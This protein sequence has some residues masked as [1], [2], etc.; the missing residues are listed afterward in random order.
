MEY[1]YLITETIREKIKKYNL[2]PR[3]LREI[4]STIDC[5]TAINAEPLYSTCVMLERR[6]R[7]GGER[8]VWFEDRRQKGLCLYILREIFM[9]DEYNRCFTTKEHVREWE[10]SHAYDELE[11]L[12]I[13]QVVND[14]LHPKK[15]LPILPQEWKVF[16]NA[17]R[18]FGD[19]Q[20]QDIVVYESKEWVEE[21][22][23]IKERTVREVVRDQLKQFVSSSDIWIR[24]NNVD[25][26][27]NGEFRE[28]M[29]GNK[30]ITIRLDA[31]NTK[32][33]A[34]YLLSISETPNYD[35][36]RKK[37][38]HKAEYVLLK[39]RM[40][41]CYPAMIL[42][43]DGPNEEDLEE[44]KSKKGGELKDNEKPLPLWLMVE[45]DKDGQANLILSAQEANLLKKAQYPFF[46]NGLAGSGKSTMLY[47][48]FA[49]VYAYQHKN[50]PEH[51]LLFLSYS[52][53]LV[54]KAR[55]YVASIL[56]LNHEFME[57]GNVHIYDDMEDFIKPFKIFLRQNFLTEEERDG[58][59]SNDKYVDYEKFQELY[60][61]SK[62]KEKNIISPDIVWSVIRIYIKG[63]N[64]QRFLAPDD[65]K[66]LI[67]NEGA[68]KDVTVD[69][70]IF[71]LAYDIW[72]KWYCKKYELDG[73]WDDLDLVR[74]IL[75]NKRVTKQYAA[76][77]C[78]EAQDFTRVET[79]LIIKLSKHSLYDLSSDSA[80]Q[81]IP[82]AFAG[83]PNQTISPTGFRVGS[84]KKLFTDAFMELVGKKISFEEYPLEI[85]YRS[86]EGIVNFSNV[87]QFIRHKLLE[88]VTSCTFQQAWDNEDSLKRNS[89]IDGFNYVAFYSLDSDSKQVLEGHIKKALSVITSEDGEYYVS[90]SDDA[91]D[92]EKS[93]AEETSRRLKKIGLDKDVVEQNNVYTAI[94]AKGLEFKSTILYRFASVEGSEKAI[95]AFQK[96][97]VSRE[98]LNDSEFYALTHF[99]TK[100]YVAVSRSKEVL[101]VLDTDE[102]YERFWK[103]LC[104][105]VLWDKYVRRDIVINRFN[106]QASF[107][108]LY[109]PEEDNDENYVKDYIKMLD[110]NFNPREEAERLFNEALTADDASSASTMRRARD[111][112]AQDNNEYMMQL[113]EAYTALYSGRMKQAGD[114]FVE[115]GEKD[116]A[117]STYWQSMSWRELSDLLDK[118]CMKK[119][120]ADFM[121][122]KQNIKHFIQKW[123]FHKEEF[124]HSAS[125]F[126]KSETIWR[127]IVDNIITQTLKI[128]KYDITDSLINSFED[129]S[130][131]FEYYGNKFLSTQATLH[132]KRAQVLNQGRE[133]DSEQIDRT[134][135]IRA[136]NQ[137]IATEQT[138]N[139]EFYWANLYNSENDSERI[140]WLRLLLKQDVILSKYSNV[141][142]A[143]QLSDES[144]GIVFTCLL[145][146]DF[147]KAV[148]Y[149]FPKD[150]NTK[151]N[152]LYA[153]NPI[154][155]FTEVVL[156]DFTPEKFYFLTDKVQ[157][158]ENNI[159][160]D[161]LP[162][163]IFDI[164]F[165]LRN[166]DES[167][168]P[169]W[170][171]F[172][173]M[174][175]DEHGNRILKQETNRI[176]ILESL[177]KLINKDGN[178]DKVLASC[179][180]EMLFDKDFNTARADKFKQTIINL[181]TQDLFFK[182]DFRR[183]TQRNKY[184]TQINDLDN[185]EHDTIKNNICR[186]AEHYLANVRKVNSSSMIGI[187]AMMRAYEICVAY[188]GIYPDYQNICTMYRKHLR[189][190]KEEEINTWM[191]QRIIFNQYLDNGILQRSSFNDFKQALEEKKINLIKVCDDFTKEDAARFIATS[192]IQEKD[193]SFERVFISAKLIYKH[194]LRRENLKPYCKVNDLLDK[195]ELDIDNATKE[196]LSNKQRIDEYAIKILAY[197]W[198]A[199]FEYSFVAEHYDGLVQNPRLTRL[200][201]LTEYLKK[202]ALLHYS[203]LKAIL[204]K[205]KQKKY[206]I[207]MSKDYLPAVYPHIEE[208]NS[209][210]NESSS[211]NTD[212]KS[213]NSTKQNRT[214]TKNAKSEDSEKRTSK[215]TAKSSLTQNIDPAKMQLFDVARTL[216]NMGQSVDFI[217]QAVSKKL[218]LEEIA[219]LWESED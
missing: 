20:F 98:E 54:Q 198:E 107:G 47:Y 49:C 218:T 56:R 25:G 207:S 215:R 206:G 45:S 156:T 157:R 2:S 72:N 29:I 183:I 174:L 48:L 176:N 182:E 88:K 96:K 80:S 108:L 136:I 70:D 171:Y 81:I 134:H 89:S 15:S 112:Y 7:P 184:F 62:L 8:I 159:F 23:T 114:M 90:S 143:S 149:P 21:F 9:H 178:Y 200:S 125:D 38:Y 155:F 212:E 93:M 64:P 133:F 19:D 217:Y 153:N 51:S 4:Q 118:P 33:N 41:R 50:Y 110:A 28:L 131:C 30:H 31:S 165:S 172:T 39:K 35:I 177:S 69:Y 126:E 190:R 150:K 132:Y 83:D 106:T 37:G 58:R 169:Y 121:T 61:G 181:F 63:Y 102:A 138:Q 188:Q 10:K 13:E 189:T 162:I 204:F 73:Y 99:F 191:Q 14:Y 144:A 219:S 161:K 24:L 129:L 97:I 167:G 77:F 120:V 168:K 94:T 208:K 84:I 71:K 55:D 196:V 135:F 152:R 34:I 3:L 139:E 59:F 42:L 105:P 130:A 122:N 209:S 145:N 79:E 74:F 123:L 103:Y 147:S 163:G 166:V 91:S 85:N 40:K 86:R 180:L 137:W 210:G 128:N 76:V 53:R 27:E 140:K 113:C 151:W 127:M 117:I 146:K 211:K 26:E 6:K 11:E 214:A 111:Y 12:E 187:K 109:K 195:L 205:D 186:Y 67:E 65:Y 201:I 95:A 66:E 154:R 185:E 57:S 22:A 46:I 197:T 142:L 115:L 78:D 18:N 119:L 5:K 199:F 17:E 124:Y 1:K 104:E 170:T 36:L 148:A 60:S 82:I 43:D 44:L 101:F 141:E 160:D 192:G 194:R 75:T 158:E 32:V 164:I 179:F 213:Q 92:F 68:R 216:K 87:I 100:L 193:Y 175:K 173:S 116:L 16:E 203:H 202:R 52:N